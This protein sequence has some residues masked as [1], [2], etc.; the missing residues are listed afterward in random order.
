[1]ALEFDEFD[2]LAVQLAHDLRLPM[3]AEPREFLT[4]VDL[5]HVVSP[6]PL[7]K[8]QT[9]LAE[10]LSNPVPVILHRQQRAYHLLL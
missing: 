3:L 10:K 1:M 6:L 7:V 2:L 5:V 8:T 4:Q 9:P